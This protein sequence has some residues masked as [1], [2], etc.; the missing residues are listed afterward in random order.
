MESLEVGK[1]VKCSKC[2]F[3]APIEEWK[4]IEKSS[5]YELPE[6]LI[7]ESEE[8]VGNLKDLSFL[9]KI[10]VKIAL[11]ILAKFRR[12]PYHEVVYVC[13]KCGAEL[14]KLSPPVPP[15]PDWSKRSWDSELIG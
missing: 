12:L 2:G 15:P 14:D 5:F 13:P 7:R 10:R 1:L 3:E 9:D 11:K 6:E 4:V 8:R